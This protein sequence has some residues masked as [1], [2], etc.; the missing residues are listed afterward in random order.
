MILLDD[1]LNYEGLINEAIEAGASKY[2]ACKTIGVSI[3]TL[4]RWQVEGEV[5]ADKRLT[6]NRPQPANK[7]TEQERLSIMTVC[8]TDEFASLPPSQIV[9]V[10]A[11]RGKY[12]ASESSFY[13]V[14]KAEGMLH[15][16]GKAKARKSTKKPTSYTT[17]K[18]NEVWSWDIS[19]LPTKV[20]GQHY[21]LYM[22]E[23]IYSRKIVGWE[24]HTNETGKQAAELLERSVW[25]EKCRKTEL[26]LHSDNGAPM[27]SLTMQAKMHDL[28]VI[29]SR[30]RPRVSNDN[31]YS[32][33]LFRTVKYCPRWPSEGFNSLDG[34]RQWVKGFVYWYNNEHRHSRIKFVTPNQRHQGLDI[35]ILEN[36]KRLYQQ[37]RNEHPE[38]WS[39]HARN[40]AHE[41]LVELNPEQNKVAA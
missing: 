39:G 37:K 12:I 32:E 6:A 13:R 33:S 3:R 40:W 18:A 26:V 1:R 7:L 27:K 24:V 10:L 14:L 36:R 21:Y 30:S 11:D 20:I 19:Y 31:P 15:H 4:Q 8:N 23:D 2:K 17:K 9:P 22:I 5:T 29:S 25:S 28:G 34:A 38:R 16:R 41:A 35:E